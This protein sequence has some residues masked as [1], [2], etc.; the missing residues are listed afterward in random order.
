MTTATILAARLYREHDPHVHRSDRRRVPHLR[1][2]TTGTAWCWGSAPPGRSATSTTRTTIAPVAVTGSLEFT[3]LAADHPHVRIDTTGKAW[4]WSRL[5]SQAGNGDA[6]QQSITVPGS[7]PA[8]IFARLT[9]RLRPPA[10]QHH[11][12]VLV[13]GPGRQRTELG[14]DNDNQANE[15]APVTVADN[16][17]S[18]P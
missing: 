5:S 12:H 8:T 7:W 15:Y 14:D 1:I 4:C 6:A 17:P 16:T 9:A 11:G 10:D 18:P 3:H 2:D 13:L